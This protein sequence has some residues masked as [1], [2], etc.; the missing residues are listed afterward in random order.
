MKWGIAVWCWNIS[1]Y[2]R[3]CECSTHTILQGSIQPSLPFHLHQG[4]KSNI[5]SPY[6]FKL[7]NIYRLSKEQVSH[8]K[9]S[10]SLESQSLDKLFNNSAKVI[11]FCI[12]TVDSRICLHSYADSPQ[13]KQSLQYCVYLTLIYVS[14][15]GENSTI[16]VESE[17]GH[18]RHVFRVVV[19]CFRH[20]VITR[21]I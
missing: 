4:Y 11:Q 14:K 10:G 5:C 18:L 17:W 7:Q 21:L 1:A 19:L 2:T 16:K 6:E 20:Q 13:Y 12:I 3:T 8:R 9:Y 15:L